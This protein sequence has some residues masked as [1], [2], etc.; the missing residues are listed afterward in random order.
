MVWHLVTPCEQ[1]DQFDNLIHFSF[2]T[3]RIMHCRERVGWWPSGSTDLGRLC[4]GCFPPSEHVF[5]LAALSF[6]RLLRQTSEAG[7][8]PISG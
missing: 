5:G 8:S 4:Q 2:L 3:A 7:L 6:T 1:F